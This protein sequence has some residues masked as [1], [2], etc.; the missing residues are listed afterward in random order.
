MSSTSSPFARQRT[1]LWLLL[2]VAGVALLATGCAGERSATGRDSSAAPTVQTPGPA[3]A[4]TATPRVQ[5]AAVPS[6]RTVAEIRTSAPASKLLGGTHLAK[7]VACEAC[8]GPLPTDGK[9]VIPNTA[10]CLTCH[11][12]SYDA[13]AAKTA[14][15]GPKNPHDP[16][17]GRLDCTECH[18]VHRPFESYCSTCHAFGTPDKYKPA[19]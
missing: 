16:H 1:P 4:A 8:H 5:P 18:H 13:L 10:K 17:D 6:T 19:S 11:G 9:P 15:L 2:L 14:A 7:G 12:G 3:P